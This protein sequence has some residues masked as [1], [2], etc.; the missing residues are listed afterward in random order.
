VTVSP[1]STDVDA[2]PADA[3]P[4]GTTGTRPAAAAVAGALVAPREDCSDP[5][6]ET[7][8]AA[9]DDGFD[10][11]AA[12]DDDCNGTGGGGGDDAVGWGKAR[13]RNRVNAASSC[14]DAVPVDVSCSEKLSEYNVDSMVPD[15]TSRGSGHTC[16]WACTDR[17]CCCCCS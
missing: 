1:V 14:G 3:P 9:D 5:A 2:P 15:S 16:S 12:S 8:A 17:C 7:D 11:I 13:K 4:D 6:L 10:A